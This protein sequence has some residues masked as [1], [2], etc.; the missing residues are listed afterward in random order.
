MAGIHQ[1]QLYYAIFSPQTIFQYE[2]YSVFGENQHFSHFTHSIVWK[3]PFALHNLIKR[4]STFKLIVT[5][6]RSDDLTQAQ[7]NLILW[8]NWFSISIMGETALR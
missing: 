2:N 8:L 7:R 6:E 5:R 4:P 3:D 1:E